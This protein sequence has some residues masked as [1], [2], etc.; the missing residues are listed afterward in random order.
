MSWPGLVEPR[1]IIVGYVD[2]TQFVRFDSDAENPRMEPRARWIEQ[3]GPE[4]WERETQK[5][6]GHEQSFRVSLRTLLSYY[7]HSEG[8]E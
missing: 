2:D 5:A 8:G 4:Y 1:F 3:E 7:N 6:K